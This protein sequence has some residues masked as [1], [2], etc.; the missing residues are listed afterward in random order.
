MMLL[1]KFFDFDLDIVYSLPKDQKFLLKQPKLLRLP[2]NLSGTTF[3]LRL[4]LIKELPLGT[5]QC[6]ALRHSFEPPNLGLKFSRLI[7]ERLEEKD[8][9]VLQGLHLVKHSRSISVRKVQ[10]FDHLRARIAFLKEAE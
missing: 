6:S 2:S 3:H 8:V 1:V 10:Y 9:A 4:E 7:E 5:G